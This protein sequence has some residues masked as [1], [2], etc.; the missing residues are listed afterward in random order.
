GGGGIF[1]YRQGRDSHTVPIKDIVYLEAS[2]RKIIIHLCDGSQDDF[3]G[4]LKEI[5]D[6]QFEGLDFIFI[7]AS[8]VV[9]FDYVEAIKYNCVTIKGSTISLPVSRSR[10]NEVR[11]RFSAI[12]K[13]RFVR[14]R[15]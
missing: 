15:F 9:N 8:Y 7:H 12:A 6:E 1:A 5:Y 4:A 14:Y 11:S 10:K 2:D 13:C 3:Y